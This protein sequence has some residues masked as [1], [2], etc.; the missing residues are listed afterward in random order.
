MTTTINE[1]NPSSVSITSKTE[2]K[3]EKEMKELA[4]FISGKYRKIMV[5]MNRASKN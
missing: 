2:V 1:L 4:R 5:E 3:T